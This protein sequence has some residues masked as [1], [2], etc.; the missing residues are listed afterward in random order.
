MPP[1][2]PISVITAPGGY[3]KDSD[4]EPNIDMGEK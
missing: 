2:P 1:P 4:E 3:L